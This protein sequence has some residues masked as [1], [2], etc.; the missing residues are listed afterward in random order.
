[1]LIFD[2][3]PRNIQTRRFPVVQCL[4]RTEPMQWR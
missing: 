2:D 4:D 3:V 1:M